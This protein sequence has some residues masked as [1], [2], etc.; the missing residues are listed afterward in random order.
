[1]SPAG[2]INSSVNDM[3]KWVITWINGGKFE[4]KEVIP[5]SYV[6][7]A[8]SSQ[9]VA[10][11]ALPSSEH[12]DLYLSNYGF[13]WLL[14]SYRGHYQVQHG[15]AIDGFSA[16]TCF[17]PSDSIGIIVL[18]NQDGSIIPSLVRNIAADHML[19]LTVIDWNKSF[20]TDRVK[21]LKS[22][23]ETDS[24]AV[25]NMKPG[26]V[27]SQKLSA[28]TGNYFNPG[29][30]TIK[31]VLDRDSLFSILP[32]KKIWLKH[33]HYDIF[34]PFE[35]TKIGIDSTEKSELRFSFHTNEMGEIESVYIKMEPTVDPLD[36]KRQPD[37]VSLDKGR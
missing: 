3:A 35:I 33:Y 19:K 15:G 37:I 25:S 20:K 8:I 34:Q 21:A 2:S 22:K 10:S 31:I 36:F 28:Y 29:Y 16:L 12:P 23:K 18:V 13:G 32:L 14:S 4:G 9:M 26:T 5:A 30:G 11:A 17:F 6:S 24:K 1:M 7:E 27:P